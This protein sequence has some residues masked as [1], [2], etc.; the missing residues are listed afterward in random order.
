MGRPKFVERNPDGSF[1]ADF[2]N[3]VQQVYDEE[4]T[5]PIVA[6]IGASAEEISRAFTDEDAQ[7]LA[8]AMDMMMPMEDDLW[9]GA[10]SKI[11]DL[12]RSDT[13]ESRVI[14]QAFFPYV[15]APLNAHKHHFYYTQPELFS[16]DLLGGLNIPGT[17]AGPWM[18]MGVPMEAAVGLA[19][20][21][22]GW[23][24]KVMGKSILSEEGRWFG[25][26]YTKEKDKM[27]QRLGWFKSQVHHKDPRVRA[28]AKSALTTAT[29]MNFAVMTAVE[30]GLI[31]ATGG[32][33]SSYQE[34]N[35]AYIPPY[36]VKIGGAWVPYRWIPYF[37]ELM[38]FSTNFRDYSRT[39][40]NFVNQSV[41]G[42]SIV[43]MAAT[44]FDTPAIAGVD[45]LISGLRNP[46]KMEDLLIDYIERT[47]GT[48]YSPVVYA[49]G[50]LTTEAYHARPLYGASPD[51]LFRS[52]KDYWKAG[53]GLDYGEKWRTLGT[54]IL[55]VP[56]MIQRTASRVANATGMLPLIEVLD[57]SLTDQDQGDFRQAHWYKPGDITYTGPR[58]R[59]VLQT[60]LGRHWPV[61]HEADAVDMELFR[62]GIKPPNQV[63]RRYG[64]IVANESMVNKFRRYLG[65]DFRFSNG[66][67]LHE[68]Y[69]KVISGEVHVPGHPGL[70]YND[71]EDDPRNSLTLDGNYVPWINRK[72]ILTKRIVLMDIRREAVAL[73]SEQFLRGE[74]RIYPGGNEVPYDEPTNLKAP[75]VA[76]QL[77]WDWRE[78]NPN[79]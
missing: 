63:F 50:R 39:E 3:R 49:L 69:R 10:Y 26:D 18:P 65:T 77:Y 16:Q 20:K 43:A 32:Q 22:Q 11:R 24:G 36:H 68:T 61:P 66:D 35:G 75:D 48:G 71:L 51:V 47:M 6:G 30:G 41:V 5:T 27:A 78:Q 37:G 60:M 45:T 79:R 33:V 67:S 13:G 54:K 34:A 2:L 19:R 31:E 25:L 55:N 46:H 7:M 44:L 56:Q 23:D 62:N 53:E 21:I 17:P 73:A 38:A 9:G 8:V 28:R 29:A 70:F 58:Q 52:E 57:Q 64:G 59:S 1:N 42:T 40:I 4:F 14:A 76:T 12:Q 72:D 15:K 74:R